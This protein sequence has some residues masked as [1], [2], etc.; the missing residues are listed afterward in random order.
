M[1]MALFSVADQEHVNK[2]EVVEFVLVNLK[3]QFMICSLHW[4]D[5]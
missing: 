1:K 5:L 2:V 3:T 4:S